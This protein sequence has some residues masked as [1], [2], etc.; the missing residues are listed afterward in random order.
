MWVPTISKQLSP[1]EVN[2]P[3]PSVPILTVTY[4]LILQFEP[5]ITFVF[6]PLYFKS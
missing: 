5:M 4:S 2:L 6:S 3:P 1:K